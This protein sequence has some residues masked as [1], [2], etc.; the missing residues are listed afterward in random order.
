MSHLRPEDIAVGHK[1]SL[2]KK[3][4]HRYGEGQ[5]IGGGILRQIC[6]TCGA[7]SIDLTGVEPASEVGPAPLGRTE[8]RGPT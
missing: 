1:K 5:S 4:Q 8:R 7:V 2:C 3:G 6:V